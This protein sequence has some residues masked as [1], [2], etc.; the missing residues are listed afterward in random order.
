MENT[1]T[2]FF[3]K[4]DE[5]NGYLSN[6]Y[7]A[8]FKLGFNTKPGELFTF[9]NVEQA[10]MASKALLMGDVKSF[11]IILNQ[12]NPK[13]VKALGRKVQNFN[14]QIWD[15]Y[16]KL[17]VKNANL[18]KFMQNPV[19]LQQLLETGNAYLA[20]DSPYDKVWGI[21]TKSASVKA[22]RTWKGQNLLGVILMEVRDEL[23]K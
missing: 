12:P 6:W 18:A 22:K 4:P 14:P 10:M 5:Q 21:G 11:N 17:I 3:F 16:K 7:P 2:I 19:L 20:E 13:K 9:S 8:P 23:R 1:D 15:Q